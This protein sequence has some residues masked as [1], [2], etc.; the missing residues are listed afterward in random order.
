M[1]GFAGIAIRM[2]TFL[3][4]QHVLDAH[5]ARPREWACSERSVRPANGTACVV[6]E[7]LVLG[8]V[9]STLGLALGIGAAAALRVPLRVRV[10]AL[11]R[12]S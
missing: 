12:A 5:A 11:G 6:I 7:A 8:F 4:L 10:G 1:L 2:G 3:I 9:G